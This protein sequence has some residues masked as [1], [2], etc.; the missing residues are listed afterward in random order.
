MRGQTDMWGQR[1]EEPRWEEDPMVDV[2]AA[3]WYWG[4]DMDVGKDGF[5]RSRGQK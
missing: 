2:G 3:G 4:G 5:W 1:W